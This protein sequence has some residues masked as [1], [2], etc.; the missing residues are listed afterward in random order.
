MRD[1]KKILGFGM[2]AVL[3]FV[4]NGC[5]K[6]GTKQESEL[7][8]SGVYMSIPAGWKLENPGMCSRGDNTCLVMEENLEGQTF[9][10]RAEQLSLEFGNTITS[11]SEM[12]INGFKAIKTIG[13]SPSGDMLIRV[14]ILKGEKIVLISFVII[15]NEYEAN[16]QAIEKS[17]QS[18][19]VKS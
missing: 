12:E 19:T 18:I 5:S 13:N 17:I 9:E 1:L 14:Y 4:C 8:L 2:M 10:K 15:K 11:K 16:K 6:K 7:S 3:F